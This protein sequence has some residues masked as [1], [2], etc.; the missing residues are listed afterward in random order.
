[1]ENNQQIF[2]QLINANIL[3]REGK[4]RKVIEHYKDALAGMKDNPFIRAM[5]SICYLQI[6]SEDSNDPES[7]LTNAIKWITEAIELSPND[8][9]LRVTLADIYWHGFND[10]GGAANEYRKAIDIKPDYVQALSGASA[11]H[12]LSEDV[13]TLDEAINW[14][15]S[16]VELAPHQPHLHFR[17]GNLY[18][19]AGR[20]VDAK[21]AWIRSLLCWKPLG[22]GE[23]NF[24]KMILSKEN[25]E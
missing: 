9:Y 7:I 13:V 15:E 23:T 8:V 22:E 11:I 2:H 21:E 10:Y 14:L 25:T 5:I 3:R 1:M 18:Q 6:Q 19:K 12:E 4:Y 24:L 17:L 16:A 20:D